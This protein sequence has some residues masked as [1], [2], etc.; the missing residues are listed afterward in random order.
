MTPRLKWVEGLWQQA[1]FNATAFADINQLIWEKYICNVMLSAPCT[2]Y[3]CTVGELFADAE[4][5]ETAL[6]AMLE[7]YAIGKAR[8]SIF[9]SMIL[10]LMP[11]PL[12]RVCRMP[13]RQC[14]LIILQGGARR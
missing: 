6:A 12:L 4:K 9:P 2:V 11:Q 3:D 5:R 1:G 8:G 14:G 13:T 10:W 7:A